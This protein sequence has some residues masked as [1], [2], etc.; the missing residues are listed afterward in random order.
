MRKKAKK[1]ADEISA[2]SA[3]IEFSGDEL[4]SMQAMLSNNI[5]DFAMSIIVNKGNLNPGQNIEDACFVLNNALSAHDKI[6]D[7]THLGNEFGMVSNEA[8]RKLHKAL[9]LE[10]NG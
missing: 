2:K 6:N 7:V 9:N 1:I 10:L 8:I 3:S 4:I 5:E